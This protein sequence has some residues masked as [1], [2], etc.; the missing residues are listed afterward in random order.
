MPFSRSAFLAGLRDMAPMMLGVAPFGMITGASAASVGLAPGEALGMSLLVFAGASQLAAIALIGQGATFAVIV[1]TTFMIN[2]RM[3]MYSASIAT[4]LRGLR[5]GTRV[6]L[7]YAMTDQAYAFSVVRFQRDPDVPRRDYYLGA[8]MPLW[9]LWQITTVA[10]AILGARVPDGWQLDFAIP[11]TFL[12]LLA[13]AVRN[14]P[15]A[16]A[17]LV[18]GGLALTLQPLPYNLGL[19][20]AALSGI[21]AGTTAERRWPPAP[22]EDTAPTRDPRRERA[23]EVER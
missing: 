21:A 9:L 20:I 6:G 14:R 10:G 7:A 13:P 19:V 2:L 23:S 1:V 15:G 16:V 18:A 5:V 3:V 8:A 12:A 11:L 17:A 4:W 22:P